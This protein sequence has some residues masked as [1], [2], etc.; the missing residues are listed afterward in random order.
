ML[1]FGI[2]VNWQSIDKDAFDG[3]KEKLEHCLEERCGVRCHL[4]NGRVQC[5]PI[6]LLQES[7]QGVLFIPVSDFAPNDVNKHQASVE[8]NYAQQEEVRPHTDSPDLC[9]SLQRTPNS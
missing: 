6:G 2:N 1:E 7:C 3:A 9:D 4:N 8:E 5:I